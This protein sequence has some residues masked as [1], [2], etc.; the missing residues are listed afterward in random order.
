MGRVLKNNGALKAHYLVKEQNM[1][2][3]YALYIFYV[4]RWDFL[5]EEGLC[6]DIS[7]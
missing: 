1:Y 6:E 3:C 2:S 7:T 4:A 5:N